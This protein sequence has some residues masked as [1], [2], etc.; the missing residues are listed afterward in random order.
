[1]N[2]QIKSEDEY[3]KNW[4]GMN[5][6]DREKYVSRLVPVIKR[7]FEEEKKIKPKLLN[8]GVTSL[9]NN[10]FQDLERTMNM[11][12][13]RN[14]LT[15]TPIKKMPKPTQK[16]K[17]EFIKNCAS[18]LITKRQAK[19]SKPAPLA[20][21]VGRAVTRQ[22]LEELNNPFKAKSKADQYIRKVK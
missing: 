11:L 15:P 5:E 8:I 3:W 1:M 4:L 7:A 13:Q 22:N 18:L 2:K 9:L 20:Q 10:Y 21:R 14:S 16:E 17:K 12:H 19:P 6:Q